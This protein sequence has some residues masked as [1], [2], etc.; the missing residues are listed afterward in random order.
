MI[1]EK[2]EIKGITALNIL[3]SKVIQI[4]AKTVILATGGYAGL[5]HNFTTNSY[6]STGDGIAAGA[7]IAGGHARRAGGTGLA[8]DGTTAGACVAGSRAG[9]AEEGVRAM[10]GGTE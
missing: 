1:V 3:D 5:Y 6:A 4:D 10:N 9:R 2:N 8:G 7:G